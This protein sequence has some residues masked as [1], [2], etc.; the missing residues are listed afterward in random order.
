MAGQ[1]RTRRARDTGR[2]VVMDFG[3]SRAATVS[4]HGSVSGTPVYMA[5]EQLRGEPL[6][7]RADLFAA[8]MVLAEMVAPEGTAEEAARQRLWA[9]LHR[10]PPESRRRPGP[11]SSPER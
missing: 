2:V 5:P 10:E 6:D 1:T 9:G 8:G 4:G 3:V 7:A 11:R